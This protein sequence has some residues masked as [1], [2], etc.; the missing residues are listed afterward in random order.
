MKRKA[1]NRADRAAERLA[2][3]TPE[4]EKERPT[5]ERLAKGG[6][7]ASK[8][9][10]SLKSPGGWGLID[11]GQGYAA[12]DRTAHPIDKMEHAGVITKD[13]AQA[14]R[15]YE[16]LAR[17]CVEVPGIRDSCT[18]WEPKGHDSDDGPVHLKPR[19]RELERRLSAAQLSELWRV[20]VEQGVPDL[21][22]RPLS[23]LR[24]GLNRC[25]RFFAPQVRKH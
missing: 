24:E 12:Q 11:T 21:A 18:I 2:Q 8:S 4:R 19:L 20:C 23:E 7:R 14:G 16:A 3:W 1:R 22:Y 6:M 15:D 13:Q 5:P 10:Q 25:A 17:S 9:G